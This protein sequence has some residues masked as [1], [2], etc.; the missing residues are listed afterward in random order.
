MEVEIPEV[1]MVDAPIEAPVETVVDDSPDAVLDAEV[2]EDAPVEDAPA[3]EAEEG[4]DKEEEPADDKAAKTDDTP[5]PVTFDH[6]AEDFTAKADEVLEKY[7]IPDEVAAVITALRAKA[8]T[9]QEAF[10]PYREYA[11]ED[12]SPET[13]VSTVKT[14]L[15][16]Q[17]LLESVEEVAP[18]AFRPKTAEF[19]AEI[20]DPVVKEWMFHD[21]GQQP[22]DKY[23]GLNKFQ[24]SIADAFGHEGEPVSA[25]MDRYAA[26]VAHMQS[27][28]VPTIDAPH[29][30]P[31][32]VRE[33]YWSLPQSV[34]DEIALYDPAN[35]NI[36]YGENG[37]QINRDAAARDEKIRQLALIQKGLN[38]D[39][40]EAVRS[41]ETR[42]QNDQSFA[43]DVA[44]TQTRFY[45]TFR[46]T[47]TKNVAEGVKFSDDP[48]MQQL[49]ATQ[50]VS[51]MAQ[52]LEDGSPGAFARKSLEEAGIKF[53]YAKAQ[54]LAKEVEKASV[55]LVTQQRM[56][57]ADGQPINKIELQKA[58]SAFERAGREFQLMAKD[59][60]D[61]Q[62]RLVSTGKAE[63][64]EK[65]VEKKKIAV[66]ARSVAKG[67]PSKS[68]K[69]ETLPNYGTPEW[70]AHWAKKE[71]AEQ[72][73]RANAYR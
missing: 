57:G 48:K 55:A 73:Q 60:I 63:D 42:R 2:V 24:E 61:Q 69:Q 26:T 11:P 39:K 14:L 25:I 62:A 71:Q 19:I 67:T 1:Q 47:F 44:Q 35:D 43:Q 70:Y 13:V 27:G 56:K 17:A 46:E 53:D 30:I 12:A 59:V 49:L 23:T 64:V 4:A 58:K 50:N 66:K 40:Q 72:A 9:P 34:R 52:A 10:A 20:A 7:E 45:D 3:E 21:L 15:D 54:S 31:N 37:Q 22:S 18:G 33:A 5:E 51:L 38:A 29:F 41:A 36:E 16:R 32:E 68:T 65:A 6:T 28:T 8:D